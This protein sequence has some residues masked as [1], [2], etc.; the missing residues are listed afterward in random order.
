MAGTTTFGVPYG[1]SNPPFDPRRYST[2]P[3]YGNLQQ[4][5][6]VQHDNTISY[7]QTYGHL[8]WKFRFMYNPSQIAVAYNGA[9]PN[10]FPSNFLADNQGVALGNVSPT[11]SFSLYLD[12]TYEINQ[13]LGHG[14]SHATGV[15]VDIDYFEKVAGI[16]GIGTGPI[17]PIPIDIYFG[18][19]HALHW[20][21][22]INSASVTYAQFTH[23]MAPMNAELDLSF[24]QIFPGSPPS[25]APS[26]TWGG[27][28][29]DT[30]G[31][32]WSSSN[33]ANDGSVTN[34]LGATH[35]LKPPNQ[36]DGPAPHPTSHLGVIPTQIIA[37]PAVLSGR[38][39][40]GGRPI[41]TPFK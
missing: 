14:F 4:G 28:S 6:M 10:R 5:Y 17:L 33:V 40:N 39:R 37:S 38:S 29:A 20:L 2:N 16:D 22:I 35:S 8:P 1:I 25:T 23:D 36:I 7:N 3:S 21:G 18:G 34:V 19:P 12:R 11:C 9:D 32:S 24:Q 13:P 30:G 15:A 26:G 31:G 27:A 41:P